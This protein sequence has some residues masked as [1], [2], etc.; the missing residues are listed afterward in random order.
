[1]QRR[2]AGSD[3][4]IDAGLR[5]LGHSGIDGVRVEVLAERLGITKGGFYRRFRDRQALLD[6]MLERWAHGRIKSIEEHGARAGATPRDRVDSMVRIYAGRINAE[7]MAIELAVRQWANSDAA[8]SAAVASVD[9]ARLKVAEKIYRDMGLT[10]KQ[11]RARAILLYSFVF[12]QSLI[13][14]DQTS[15]GYANLTAACTEIL[16]EFSGRPQ[17]DG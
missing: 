17:R 5:E 8:A 15:R 6:A 16:A 11:A 13:L 14:L 12:G 1:M 7:G 10:P 9:A 4:W 3:M 2:A